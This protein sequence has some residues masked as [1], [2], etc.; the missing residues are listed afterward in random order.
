MK[1]SLKTNLKAI[2]ARSYVRFWAANREPSWL[3]SETI[4]PLLGT[5]AYVFVYKTLKAP[6]EYIGFVILGGTMSAYWM[7]VLWSMAAQFYWEKEMGNLELFMI[8]P[9]SRMSILFGMAFGGFIHA[10]TRAVVIFLMGSLLFKVSFVMISFTKLILV[11]I[12]TLVALYG[13]G[14]VFSSVF[15]LYGREAWHGVNLLQEPVYLLSG[16]YFPVK[17][18]GFV[19]ALTASLIPLTLGLDAMRQLAFKAGKKYGFMDVDLEL[20]IL[21]ALCV[22]F[23]IAA[24]YALK[25][26]ENLGKKEGRLTL[27]WQ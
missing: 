8:A 3:L 7:N 21:A 10:T 13:L 17:S 24:S 23:L 15:M 19:T 18:L 14:M 27:R 5:A 20:G 4:M 12:L 1:T 26:M 16:F 22:L 11:F 9:I 2:L 6:E 25:Y